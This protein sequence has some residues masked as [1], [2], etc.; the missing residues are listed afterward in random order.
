TSIIIEQTD[1]MVKQ[2]LILHL[3][4]LDI[5]YFN[6]SVY[7][8]DF[9]LNSKVFGSRS[10]S[11]A[12]FKIKKRANFYTLNDGVTIVIFLYFFRITNKGGYCGFYLLYEKRK[13]IGFLNIY[14]GFF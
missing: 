3:F 14:P 8:F 13:L 1:R 6:L 12:T 9:N 5:P 7:F 11:K 2:V 4:D 10:G